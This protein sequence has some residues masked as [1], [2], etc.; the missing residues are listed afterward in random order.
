MT[1]QN[2]DET[3]VEFGMQACH[4]KD[5]AVRLGAALR[6]NSLQI[7]RYIQMYGASANVASASV[8][9]DEHAR[10]LRIALNMYEHASKDANAFCSGGKVDQNDK[11]DLAGAMK[12][13]HRSNQL[14]SRFLDEVYRACRR[15]WTQF[16]IPN[17]IAGIVVMAGSLLFTHGILDFS[18]IYLCN[19]FGSKAPGDSLPVTGKCPVT[20][21]FAINISVIVSG[22]Y[23]HFAFLKLL[24]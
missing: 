5:S 11:I 22:V 3:S 20:P 18:E 24:H 4:D 16:D 15:Q 14:M 6:I 19:G 8:P 12:N 9:V 1:S 23:M 17:M 7:L 13:L 10:S 2:S 21:L